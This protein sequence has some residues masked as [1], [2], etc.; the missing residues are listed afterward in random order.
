LLSAVLLSR[1]ARS[2]EVMLDEAMGCV[3]RGELAITEVRQGHGEAKVRGALLD[4]NDPWKRMSGTPS[5]PP[6]P[7]ESGETYANRML[8]LTKQSM[9]SLKAI[10]GAGA[11]AGEALGERMRAVARLNRGQVAEALRSLEHVRHQAEGHSHGAQCQASLALSLALMS[12]GRPDGCM[13]EALDAL[14]HAR[15]AEDARAAGACIALLA[16]LFAR[17]GRTEDAERL[18]AELAHYPRPSVLPPAP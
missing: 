12:A 3:V 10:G 9:R 18:A 5:R 2:G 11:G 14:A 16:K 7:M 1:V 6:P 17:V 8:E 15:A 13:L 4:A